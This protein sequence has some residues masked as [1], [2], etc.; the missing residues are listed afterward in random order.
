[1]KGQNQRKDSKQER[2]GRER[3]RENHTVVNKHSQKKL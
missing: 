3:E 1:M 2:Y